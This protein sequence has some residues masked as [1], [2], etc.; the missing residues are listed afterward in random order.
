MTHQRLRRY[1]SPTGN[2]FCEVVKVGNMIFLRGQVGADLDGRTVGIGDA[3]AQARQALRNVKTLL[4]EAG[5]GL[6]DICKITVY[7][8]D[9]AHREAV[10]RAIGEALR[11]VYP[12]STG[13]IVQGL[14]KPE[15][16]MEIDI[17][18]VTTASEESDHDRGD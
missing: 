3:G 13:L 8:T 16:L 9:R 7:I 12:V 1:T 5:A 14:A 6:E 17:I 4:A 10:Y 18:A 11:G 2:D 15:Y